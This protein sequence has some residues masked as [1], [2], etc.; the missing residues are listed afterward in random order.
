MTHAARTNL[1]EWR[2]TGV[3]AAPPKLNAM[4]AA[5][6]GTPLRHFELG[7]PHSCSAATALYA[8]RRAVPSAARP[9]VLLDRPCVMHTASELAFSTTMQPLLCFCLRKVQLR[10]NLA[11]Q[12]SARHGIMIWC[13]GKVCWSVRMAVGACELAACWS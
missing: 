7:S 10:P 6:R 2:H 11:T 5:I 13:L 3:E 9:L 4:L 12:C 8:L 1:P